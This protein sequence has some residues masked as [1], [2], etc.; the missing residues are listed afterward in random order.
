MAGTGSSLIK[1]T[2]YSST[3][4]LDFRTLQMTNPVLKRYYCSSWSRELWSVCQFIQWNS[5][6]MSINAPL[7]CLNGLVN[8]RCYIIVPLGVH[9]RVVHILGYEVWISWECVWAT[10][11]RFLIYGKYMT[12]ENPFIENVAGVFSDKFIKGFAYTWFRYYN[13]IPQKL[14]HMQL[15]L[16]AC[17]KNEV[18]WNSTVD[19]S[20]PKRQQ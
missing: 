13:E 17:F 11:V 18:F 7:N 5:S 8:G 6:L 3:V 16:F 1:R 4:S 20:S 9:N 12:I 15:Q 14:V 19:I 10:N 2:S